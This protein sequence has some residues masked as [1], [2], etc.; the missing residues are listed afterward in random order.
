MGQLLLVRHGQAS[1]GGDDYDVLSDRGE[2]QAAALGRSLAARGV[3]PAAVVH[4]QMK[5]Q[6]RT[7]ELLVE[8]AGWQADLDCDA[9]WDEMDH[10]EVL[11]RTPAPAPAD[12]RDPSPRQFQE[13]F[14]AATERWVTGDAD[15]DYTET[16]GAFT[17]RVQQALARAGERTAQGTVVVVTSGGP[18]SWVVT[19]LLAAGTD[20]YRRLAPVVVN[21]SVTKVVSGRRGLS[22]VSFND[23]A[24]LEGDPAM[25]TYR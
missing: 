18:V 7:A 22:L 13:W 6:Q 4:G 25:L 9:A 17:A 16:F 1:F 23:H 21:S 3:A 10:L 20:S 8:A 24:H 14:E 12:G 15:A 19:H 5:R 11:S 2:R